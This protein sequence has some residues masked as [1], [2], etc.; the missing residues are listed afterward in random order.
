M[1][2]KELIDILSQYPEDT[3]VYYTGD[4][5]EYYGYAPLGGRTQAQGDREVVVIYTK[6]Q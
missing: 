4:G 6:M 5:K 3:E 2:V 1:K